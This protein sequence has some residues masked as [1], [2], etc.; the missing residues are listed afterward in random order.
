V[1]TVD[2]IFDSLDPCKIEIFIHKFSTYFLDVCFL[3]WDVLRCLFESDDILRRSD[4]FRLRTDT[5]L[6]R[7]EDVLD[8]TEDF[9]RD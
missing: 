1:Q 8:F 3:R 5:D 6:R 9:F 7:L 4:N 2:I